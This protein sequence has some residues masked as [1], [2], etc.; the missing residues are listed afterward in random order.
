MLLFEVV[1][2]LLGFSAAPEWRWSFCSKPLLRHS[3]VKSESEASRRR[4][5]GMSRRLWSISPPAVRQWSCFLCVEMGENGCARSA[6]LSL[7]ALQGCCLCCCC[8]CWRNVAVEQCWKSP[9]DGRLDTS[10]SVTCLVLNA[11]V[12]TCVKPPEGLRC[13]ARPDRYRERKLTNNCGFFYSLWFAVTLA[14]KCC[15]TRRNRRDLNHD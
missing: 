11:S 14:W 8:C 4:G 15:L 9:E 2:D 7:E 1:L 5:D 3:E 10:L 13:C 12:E 6:F